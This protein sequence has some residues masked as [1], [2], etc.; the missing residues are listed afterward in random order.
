MKSV[1][2]F[3][4]KVQSDYRPVPEMLHGASSLLRLAIDEP[5]GS[6]WKLMGA[7]LLLSGAVEGF[8]NTVGPD[9]FGSAWDGG[10]RPMERRGP[11]EK[12]R[13]IARHVKVPFSVGR[14]PWKEMKDLVDTRNGLMHPRPRFRTVEDVVSCAAGDC[15]L[16]AE[17]LAAR[18]WAPLLDPV[19]AGQTRDAVVEGIS[20]LWVATGR[21][22]LAM[23]LHGM[24]IRGI[25]EVKK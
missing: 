15:E 9:L 14:P 12:L 23:R 2:K 1:P 7:L 4:I 5:L 3:Y 20:R 6:H 18:A 24:T 21:D 8:C 11:V 13:A 25:S 10:K 19:K 17:K 16:E 22:P